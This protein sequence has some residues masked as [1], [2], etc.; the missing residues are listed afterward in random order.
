MENEFCY[1]CNHP[2]LEY[3]NEEPCV[4]CGCDITELANALYVAVVEPELTW[5]DDLPPESQEAWLR[6]ALR[7][8]KFVEERR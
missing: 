8:L 3:V 5:W 6:G 7:L 4:S 2:H 1:L